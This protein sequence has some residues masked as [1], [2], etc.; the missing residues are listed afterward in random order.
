MNKLRTTTFKSGL[1]GKLPAVQ[2]IGISIWDPVWA[3]KEHI[4]QFSEL[5]HIRKGEVVLHLDGKKYKSKAGDTL[6]VP[7]GHAHR[8]EFP[9]DSVFEALHVQF[10]W[11]DM[12]KAFRGMTN[13]HLAGL[14]LINK[15][16]VKEMLLDLYHTFRASRPLVRE[17]TDVNLCRILLFLMGVVRQAGK[18]L[19]KTEAA[20]QK[21]LRQQKIDAVKHYVRE[22]ISRPITLTGVADHLGMSPFHLSHLFS[23]ESGFTLSAYL[24]QTRMQQAARLLAEPNSRVAEVGCAVGFEDPNYFGKAFRRYF[25]QSP[26]AFR[27]QAVRKTAKKYPK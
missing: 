22:N 12:E 24:T 13:A 3:K 10:I 14:S 6:F 26:G 11:P 8:D 1:S 21:E 5:V 19:T 27:A 7:A 18:P 23:Q 17:M 4:G 9:E 20:M 15:Q 16:I 25:N 2:S